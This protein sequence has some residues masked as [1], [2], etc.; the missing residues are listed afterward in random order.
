[1][2]KLT[3]AQI[4][5]MFHGRFIKLMKV[6]DFGGSIVISVFGNLSIEITM[7]QEQVY[8][9]SS[10]YEEHCGTMLFVALP[11]KEGLGLLHYSFVL[12]S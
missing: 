2:S 7:Y 6:L 8:V 4:N 9:S 12:H 10:G 11:E 5:S 1:M 3:T